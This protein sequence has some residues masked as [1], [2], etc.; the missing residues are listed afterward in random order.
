MTRG[1]SSCL[2]K[3]RALQLLLAIQFLYKKSLFRAQE[4]H[5]DVSYTYFGEGI[6]GVIALHS[7]YE[8]EGGSSEKD[9]QEAILHLERVAPLEGLILDLRDNRGGYLTQAVK[10]AGLFIT[11][12]VVA[13]SRF[14]DG[15]EKIY[16][17]IEG[18]TTFDGPLLI[19]VSRETASAAEIVAQALQ[20]YGVAVVAGDDH[21]FGKGTIQSQTVTEGTGAVY[22]KVTVGKY[23]TVSGKTPEESGVKSDIVIPG[24]RMMNG[25][26][27]TLQ[28][29]SISPDTVEPEFLD[30]L[31]DIKQEA[32]PWFLKYYIPKLQPPEDHWEKLLPQLVKNSQERVKENKN[33]QLFLKK[34]PGT[35]AGGTRRRRRR[36]IFTEKT[37]EQR[38]Q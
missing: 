38:R 8:G 12:G 9:V 11:N 14:S 28:E 33:Y 36:G 25:E 27:S 13:I 5:V 32:K 26:A 18:K 17:D 35:E 7:F 31:S 22:F 24:N 15:S 3:E 16:R 2:L 19:L 10:V 20:D 34:K 4:T 1:P 23:Y 6:I 29:I 30:D 37:S 21:T